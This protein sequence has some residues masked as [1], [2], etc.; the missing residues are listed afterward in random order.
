MTYCLFGA[1]QFSDPM[2]TYY[3]LDFLKWI[4]M[5]FESKVNNFHKILQFCLQ[6]DVHFILALLC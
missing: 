1:K 2:L 3:L 5:K 6:I 4:S